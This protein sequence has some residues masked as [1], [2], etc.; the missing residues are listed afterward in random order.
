MAEESSAGGNWSATPQWPTC[1]RRPKPCAVS[2]TSN[3][4]LQEMVI[5]HLT[6][7]RYA[8]LLG[9]GDLSEREARALV[10][11]ARASLGPESWATLE[12]SPELVDGLRRVLCCEH[13]VLWDGV[14][15][16]L[17]ERCLG[18]SA[19]RRADVAGA[20]RADSARPGPRP[21]R[22]AGRARD[23]F[24]DRS[25]PTVASGSDSA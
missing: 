8:E 12:E 2:M 7:L 20:A 14:F 22:L 24:L 4:V 15:R 6:G 18:V 9:S 13:T 19:S 17:V 21:L 10:K 23:P 3:R 25:P 11:E 5:G 16:R 1:R